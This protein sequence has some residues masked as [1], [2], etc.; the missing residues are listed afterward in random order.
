LEMRDGV[1]Y[2]VVSEVS[3]GPDFNLTVYDE[4]RSRRI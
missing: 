4:S 3:L 2:P 1:G